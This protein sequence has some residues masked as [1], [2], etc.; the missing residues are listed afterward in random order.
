[1]YF[2]VFFYKQK[3]EYEMRISDWSSDVCSSDLS[4]R[5]NN[6]VSQQKLCMVYGGKRQCHRAQFRHIGQQHIAV[7]QAAKP[8]LELLA[9]VARL[10]QA[11]ARD[12]AL[13][14]VIIL[15]PCQRPVDARRAYFQPV[16]V[17]DRVRLV[18]QVREAAA[19]LTDR[20]STRLNS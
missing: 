5:C 13:P 10:Q 12:M 8:A 4:S 11:D 16:F 3:S 1:M 17:F 6:V 9:P 2:I 18:Q 14:V 19:D 15:R 7:V 20:K